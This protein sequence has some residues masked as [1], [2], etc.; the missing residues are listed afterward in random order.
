MTNTDNGLMR[1]PSSEV[2]TSNKITIYTFSRGQDGV[3]RYDRGLQ[4]NTYALMY[5]V[6]MT[7]SDVT[8]E[9]SA[10]DD[11]VMH[12]CIMQVQG[13]VSEELEKYN[14]AILIDNDDAFLRNMVPPHEYDSIN[15]ALASPD[16]HI[17]FTP[18]MSPP[19][20]RLQLPFIIGETERNLMEDFLLAFEQKIAP[21][22][23]AAETVLANRHI[24]KTVLDGSFK[25]S[26]WVKY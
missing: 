7:V 9:G 11:A 18:D 8:V 25:A 17:L 5:T 20:I 16:V 3:A 24:I 21:R 13:I 14:R 22:I 1:D 10:Y 2:L 6:D 23:Y 15:K 19:P 4:Y 12:G 26:M